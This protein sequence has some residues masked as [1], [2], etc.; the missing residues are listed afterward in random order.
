MKKNVRMR[1]WALALFPA[2]LFVT[3][4]AALDGQTAEEPF[5]K[6]AQKSQD[7]KDEASIDAKA[8]PVLHKMSDFYKQL[9]TLKMTM[10]SRIVM[11]VQQRA[12]EKTA[13]FQ[14]AFA[15]PNKLAIVAQG[16]ESESNSLAGTTVADG[17]DVYFYNP[18]A[19]GYVKR[20]Q[21]ADVATI[22]ET[23]DFQLVS[24][25]VSRTSLL[26]A[27]V[28]A[29]PYK[30]IMADVEEV[31]YAGQEK[32]DGIDT[33][34][35]KFKQANYDWD[36]WVD[37]GKTPW[38]RKVYADGSKMLS[39]SG[40]AQGPM[41]NMKMGIHISYDKMSAN[42][43]LE[44]TAFK[45][46]KPQNAQELKSFLEK[47][48]EAEHPLVSKEAPA[49]KADLLNGEKFELG[50]EKDKNIVVLDFWATWCG[51]CRRAMPVLV[52]VTKSYKNKGVVFYAVNQGEKTDEIKAFL[53]DSGMDFNVALDPQGKIGALYGVNGIPQTVII[54]KSGKIESI[55]VGLAPDL[56]SLLTQ[57]LDTL[58]SG[59][60]LASEK[61]QR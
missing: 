18:R 56:K 5:K 34:H 44:A 32:A 29:D 16:P 42:P 59:K 4:V 52:E 53:K 47:K 26:E 7:K 33:H 43:T 11:E 51:P 13:T 40:R 3:C 12:G 31:I 25:G 2:L 45:F 57:E 35:L 14:V 15:R 36:M 27:L 22:F 38:L 49:F 61:V 1:I 50:S 23:V 21:P 54:G 30:Q 9:K 48:K 6:E 10:N 60:G 46:E 17:T 19:A 8:D 37:A 20:T 41:A 58:V 39:G 55:H 28:D 24:G